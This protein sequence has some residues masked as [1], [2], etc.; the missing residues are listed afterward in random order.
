[1]AEFE[2]S[3]KKYGLPFGVSSHDDRFLNW[4]LPAFGADTS[5]PYNGIPYD[6]HLT[7]K[8]GLGKWWEGMDPADLYGLPPEKRTQDWIEEVKHN[9]MLRHKELAIKYDVYNSYLPE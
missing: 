5:G 7:S 8:D 2:K 3:S 9:W 6:G 1:M 4:W